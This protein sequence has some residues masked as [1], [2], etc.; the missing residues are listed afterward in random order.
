M[1][2]GWLR[3]RLKFLDKVVSRDAYGEE[4]ITWTE[5][6][7]VW[8]SVEPMRGREYLDSRQQQAE[9]DYRVRIRYRSGLKPSMR[10]EHD[11]D[12]RDAVTLEIVDIIEPYVRGVD[13]ELMCRRYRED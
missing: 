9:V 13:M 7:T 2:A 11:L 3:H 10:I 1:K 6:F 5:V 8:G 12:S 4:D